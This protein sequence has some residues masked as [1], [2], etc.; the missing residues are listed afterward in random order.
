MYYNLSAYCGERG[1]IRTMDMR[2]F[3]KIEQDRIDYLLRGALRSIPF[4]I[5]L[6]SLLAIILYL[7]SLPFWLLG[8]WLAGI[9]T[10]SFIRLIFCQLLLS[11]DSLYQENPKLI[12]SLFLILTFMTGLLWTTVY[13]IGL[14]YIPE[15]HEFIIILVFGGMCAGSI[16]SLSAYLPAFY[17]Y[18]LPVF[19]P[20][21]V[22]NFNLSDFNRSILAAMFCLF[23]I[24]LGIFANFNAVLLKR[25]ISLSS[26][27]D[28]LI[29]KLRQLS[30]TDDLT[31]LY[32]RRYFE[33]RLNEEYNRARRNEQN[34]ALVSIDVDNFKIINDNCGH[35]AGDAFLIYLSNLL[36]ENFHRSNDVVFRV[37]GDEFSAILSNISKSGAE[38]VC[39]KIQDYFAN[40]NFENNPELKICMPGV[41]KKVSLSIGIIYIPFHVNVDQEHL[42][43]A[44]DNAL[45]QA[46]NQGKNNIKLVTLS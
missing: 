38:R 3:F 43:I 32:N 31:G 41:T 35:L 14:P 39:Q 6:A 15:T 7:T 16:A 1:N 27:K 20:V 22:Y 25:V 42:L 11:N 5:V 10:I 33:T 44:V 34:M 4:N 45:Y 29:E 19:I 36:K 26:E 17:A 30:V 12:V 21:I 28:L 23:V 40:M 13:F 9:M 18:L 2:S 8:S 24:G 46:K 37:G